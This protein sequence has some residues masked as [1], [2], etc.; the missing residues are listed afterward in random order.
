MTA[1][2]QPVVQPSPATA[3]PASDYDRG[4]ARAKQDLLGELVFHAEQYLTDHGSGSA[5]TRKF[6]YRFIARL[7]RQWDRTDDRHTV[8]DGLGI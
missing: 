8:Q 6:L 3:D 7:E 5:W 4:Y 1:A 2:T